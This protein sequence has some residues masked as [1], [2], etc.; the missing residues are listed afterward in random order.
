MYQHDVVC[1]K[2][3]TALRPH[4]I[5]ALVIEM[6]SFG[7]Y[8]VWAADLYKCPGCGIEIVTGFGPAP[9]RQDHYK[10]DFA[11][12]LENEKKISP[13]VIYQYEKPNR[14]IVTMGQSKN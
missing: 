2:C 6:A 3:Q 7:P 13:R 11:E 5:G 14:I 4:I 10:P 9:I 12:W 1:V 8:K